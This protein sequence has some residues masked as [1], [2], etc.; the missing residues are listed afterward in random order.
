M[1][2]PSSGSATKLNE[3]MTPT[4]EDAAERAVRAAEPAVVAA[5]PPVSTKG[6]RSMA[7]A[8]KDRDLIMNGVNMCCLPV[9]PYKI[10]DD[11]IA[12]VQ[13]WA[14][15]KKDETNGAGAFA[16]SSP[17]QESLN[18]SIK[19]GP[20][21][22]LLCDRNG[23]PGPLPSDNSMPN[24]E[25]EKCNCPW[26]VWIE[27]CE[28]GWT[29]V[30]LPESARKSL[31]EPGATVANIHNHALLQTVVPAELKEGAPKHGKNWF[32]IKPGCFTYVDAVGLAAQM[33]SIA[34][35]S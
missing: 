25:T 26:G 17:K 11:M 16:I 1:T 7:A 15:G 20:R 28:E 27:Q 33:A 10:E 23:N 8:H 35:R 34:F 9:G 4:R 19:R 5:P 13:A 12:A 2:T 14:A 24:R 30:E 21:R 3:N 18:L 31:C 6:L 29:T 32:G 22:L